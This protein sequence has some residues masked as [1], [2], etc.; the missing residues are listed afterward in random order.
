MVAIVSMLDAKTFAPSEWLGWGFLGARPFN[1]KMSW[2]ILT[3]CM[4][5]C[6]DVK[7]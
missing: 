3:S 5:T 2:D 6:Q 7:G 1:A 4:G